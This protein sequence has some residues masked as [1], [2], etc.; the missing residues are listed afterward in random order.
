MRRVPSKF[1]AEL[2][3]GPVKRAAGSSESGVPHP[4]AALSANRL[5]AT[6]IRSVDLRMLLK[7]IARAAISHTEL[8]S[9]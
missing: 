6:D 4:F 8:Q 2:S 1:I 9:R 3:I 7:F 5:K